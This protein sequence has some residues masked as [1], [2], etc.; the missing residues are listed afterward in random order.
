MATVCNTAVTR[1]YGASLLSLK[2]QGEID[3]P[4]SIYD[5]SVE[6]IYRFVGT[7]QS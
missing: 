3:V 2:S 5:A 6:R 1:L 4:L 7:G